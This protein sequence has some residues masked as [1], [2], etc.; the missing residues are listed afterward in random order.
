MLSEVPVNVFVLAMGR[1]RRREEE[2][3]LHPDFVRV[4]D[5]PELF[6][7]HLLMRERSIKLNLRENESRESR[8]GMRQD[9][10]LSIQ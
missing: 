10:S 6:M 3:Y 4:F 1:V 7:L 5:D 9:V 8:I 2:I